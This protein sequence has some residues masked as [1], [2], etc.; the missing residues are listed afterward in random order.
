MKQKKLCEKAQK[1]FDFWAS[2]TNNSVF[3]NFSG[4]FLDCKIFPKQKH[5]NKKNCVVM[6]ER[7]IVTTFFK[8]HK[9]LNGLAM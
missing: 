5:C 8:K 3:L 1:Q 6:S 7:E 2:P 4:L 9:Y